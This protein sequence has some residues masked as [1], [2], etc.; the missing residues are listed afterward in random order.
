MKKFWLVFINEYKRHVLRKRFIFAILSMP[1][2]VGFMVL[3]GFLSV[4]LQYNKLP[5]GYIAPAGLLENAT[6]VPAKEDSFMPGVEFIRYVDENTAL[7]D[8]KSQKIQAYFSLDPNYLGNGQVTLVK[9]AKAGTNIEGDFGDF[10]TFNLLANEPAKISTRLIE[11]ANLI[12]RSADGSRELAAD[13]WMAIMLPMLAGVL[14]LIAVNISG[15]Y[16]L[17][18]VVEEKENRT[19]EII[20]TSVSPSQLMAGKVIGDLLV[21]LTELAAWLLFA[22]LAIKLVPEW[23][24]F[25]QSVQIDGSSLLLIAA[26]YLPA[27]VMIAAA[28]GAVGASATQSREAQQVAGLFTL[29]IVLPFWFI[30]AIMFHPNG[31][32]ATW[33]SIIPLTAP[34]AMPLRAVFTTVPVWQIILTIG[35][36]DLMAIFMVWLAGR[37]FRTGMLQYGKRIT[38]KEVFGKR[39]LTAGQK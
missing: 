29:P 3:V 34:I 2:F 26:I 17:Q 23:L 25:A 30:T 14:F 35:L 1:I 37:I 16:L 4:W 20:V 27:F 33:L 22:V 7:A 11:G 21:G 5:V 31:P 38:L 39:T 10:L 13:N 24:P 28:M 36:L 19:M 6:P 8:V 32:I 18:A 12:V 15:G 9:G